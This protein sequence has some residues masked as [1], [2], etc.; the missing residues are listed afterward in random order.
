[1]VPHPWIIESLGLTQVAQ[2]IIELIERSMKNWKTDL[3]AFGRMLGTVNIKGVSSKVT[4]FL[5]SYLFCV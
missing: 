5:L 4:A 1:M 3:T 2:N